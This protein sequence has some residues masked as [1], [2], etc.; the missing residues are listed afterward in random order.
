MLRQW[1][2]WVIAAALSAG[3]AGCAVMLSET[4]A[5]P[6]AVVRGTVDVSVFYDDLAPYG[7]WF[8]YGSYG[9]VW[10]PYD[11]PFGWRPY[12]DG[13]WIYT[14][15]GWTWVSDWPWG[16]APFHYGRWVF[17]P[18]YGWVWV[19]GHVWAPA[20]VAWR[21]GDGWVGWAPLPPGVD[22]QVGIGLRF[23]DLDRDIASHGWCFAQQRWILDRRVRYKVAPA[24]RNLTLIGLTKIDTRYEERERRP[25]D[26][27]LDVAEVE[28]RIGRPVVRYTVRD[29]ASPDLVR[30]G[31]L[32]A[33]ELE[34]FRPQVESPT[35]KPP[36]VTP[37]PEVR[38]IPEPVLRAHEETEHRQLES[39]IRRERRRLETEQQR[40]RRRAPGIAPDEL[41][42]R[43]EDERRALDEQLTRE[44]KVV[45]QRL[46][47]RIMPPETGGRQ[48]R[49]ARS[50]ERKKR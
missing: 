2:R 10:T 15:Y 39:Y 20:W 22:W 8:T 46:E 49:S 4:Q 50:E 17:D 29:A 14:D 9:W 45:E 21:W 3:A 13:H 26:R 44:R 18:D 42:R 1:T 7:H 31:R 12:T 27:G 19:P 34:V 30:G 38:A 36:R 43:H 11:V 48:G 6:R 32:R 28:R 5:H 25:V 24:H 40:E 35:Q 23:G 41:R 37:R 16:W 47:K 33:Q